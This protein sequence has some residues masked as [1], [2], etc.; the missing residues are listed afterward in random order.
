MTNFSARTTPAVYTSKTPRNARNNVC[1]PMAIKQKSTPDS[2][3]RHRGLRALYRSAKISD[4]RFR[5]VLFEFVSDSTMAEAAQRTG[6]SVNSV[7]H[8][9]RSLRVFFFEVGL[10]TDFYNGE[11]PAEWSGD[12]ETD[13]Y[14][15]HLLEYHFARERTKR[16]FRI[17]KDGKDYHLAESEW[18]FGF[19]MLR[20]QRPD[21]DFRPMMLAHLLK[22]I[23][24]CGPVGA[25]PLHRRAGL[26]EIFRQH[27][28]RTAW[29]ERSAPEF[30]DPR[31]R[32]E[33]REIRT[34]QPDLRK[35]HR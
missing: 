17:A 31:S 27:D 18:R 6:L 2:S 1:N 22:L 8:I 23:R 4:E 34:I 13:E 11:D 35:P 28:Q 10:F 16:G 21:A 29:L 25:N 30:R 9:F 14:E 7:A 19:D 32:A 24:L 5:K 3:A 15:F 20:R 33:L 26:I 12:D